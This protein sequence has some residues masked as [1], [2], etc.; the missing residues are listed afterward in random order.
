MTPTII[1]GAMFACL[2]LGTLDLAGLNSGL[3]TGGGGV[4]SGNA[5]LAELRDDCAAA[6]LHTIGP[7]ANPQA[8]ERSE[9][10]SRS[11]REESRARSTRDAGD[12]PFA[13][14]D[15]APGEVSL[16]DLDESALERLLTA[17]RAAPR[18]VLVGHADASGPP[19]LNNQLSRVRAH[20]VAKFLIERG[21]LPR[22]V[23]RAWR[24]STEPT[25]AG[26]DRRVDVFL[27]GA[28]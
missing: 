14:V 6:P 20:T 19:A 10:Q 23:Q 21:V 9:P 27:G 24:G 1:K 25:C 12:A 8:L 15:F 22:R 18:I 2:G 13:T 3:F 4:P 28:P 7:A 16:D 26:N 5:Q 11:A 17:M